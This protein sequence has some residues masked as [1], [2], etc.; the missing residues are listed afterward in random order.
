MLRTPGLTPGPLLSLYQSIVHQNISLTETLPPI[1]SI[2]LVVFITLP[3]FAK[4]L[5]TLK[6]TLLSWGFIALPVLV[7][8]LLSPQELFTSRG[9][10]IFVTLGPGTIFTLVVIE[11]NKGLEQKVSLLSHER[12]K[13]QALSER[14]S[15]TQLHNRRGMEKLLSGLDIREKENLGVILFDIDHFKKI[16]DQYGHDVGDAV[17][18]QVAQRCKA[19]LRQDDW[20]ARWGGEEFLASFGILRS[21]PYTKLPST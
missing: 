4:P 18:R 17:L 1:T 8:L 11:L 10:D 21:N 19:A 9:M 6:I 16:N 7:Y 14:D 3:I 15:L 12:L 13:M 20:L 5:Q 2:L